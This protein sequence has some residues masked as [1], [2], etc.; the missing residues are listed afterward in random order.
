MTEAPA[1]S[2]NFCRN[3]LSGVKYYFFDYE[4]CIKFLE[5]KE[6]RTAYERAFIEGAKDYIA[7]VNG[8]PYT[9][10]PEYKLEE[11]T[12]MP[13]VF[14]YYSAPG[15]RGTLY[16]YDSQAIWEWQKYNVITTGCNSV[17]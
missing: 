8:V 17:C 5:K 9:F 1:N 4:G 12:Y 2:L 10:R 6:P 7:F 15:A 14:E 13:G 3:V 11:R 16:D